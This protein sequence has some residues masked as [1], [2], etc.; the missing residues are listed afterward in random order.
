[1]AMSS[2]N[3]FRLIFA[4]DSHSSAPSRELA[5]GSLVVTRAD[6]GLTVQTRDGRVRF[7]IIDFFGEHLSDMVADYFQISPPGKHMPRVTIDRLV[8]C[9]ES[10]RFAPDE[11]PFVR[12]SN[13]ADRFI[14]FRRWAGAHG[15]PRF[16][17]VR[18]PDERKPIYVD[19]DSPT[20]INLLTRVIRRS[21]E[22]KQGEN[23]ITVTEMLPAFDQLWLTDAGDQRYTSEFRFVIL[24]T[25]S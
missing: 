4:S 23:M 15:M 22:K 20:Y 3:D 6:G 13:E 9:R 10:W 11:M 16:I 2:D 21:A 7:D 24:D 12:E 17:F 25:A 18:T 14:A 8:A 5:V 19:S 1:M